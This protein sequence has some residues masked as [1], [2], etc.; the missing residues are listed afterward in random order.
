MAAAWVVRRMSFTKH[1]GSI[2]RGACFGLLIALI[3]LASGDSPNQ[4]SAHVFDILGKPVA[5]FV[6]LLEKVFGL[7]KAGSAG[8]W[9][10]FHFVYWM[11][12]GALAGWGV[13]IVRSKAAGD[14]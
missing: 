13:G 12:L 3:A 2:C 9:F 4:T 6:W 7:S 8:L 14:E 5:L 11:L 1:F 10:L